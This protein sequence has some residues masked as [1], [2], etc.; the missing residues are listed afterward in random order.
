MTIGIGMICQDSIV[1]ASDS[2][3]SF[4]STHKNSNADKIVEI[5][6]GET[7]VVIA[8]SGGLDFFNAL[9]EYI[10]LR[11][12]TTE[13]K[14]Q[15]SIPDAVQLAVRD[16]KTELFNQAI[17]PQQTG[18]R[19]DEIFRTNGCELMLGY[20]FQQKTP[21]IYRV[22]FDLGLVI[23][24][25]KSFYVH[26]CAFELA[27]Y[28]LASVPVGKMITVQAM[29][30]AAYVVEMAKNYDQ[31]CGGRTRI[32]V[33]YPKNCIV[34]GEDETSVFE[35]AAKQFEKRNQAQWTTSLS[36]VLPENIDLIY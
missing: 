31:K 11:A 18:E 19:W 24:E 23:P 20:Y 32:A 14:T 35:D 12:I 5:K 21:C 8:M 27:D 13:I 2:Q 22:D 6:F 10:R 7:S 26:G 28:I 25:P 17:G 9:C 4:N 30:T 15:R 33:V 29:A 1:L 36:S 3:A 16:L 34:L